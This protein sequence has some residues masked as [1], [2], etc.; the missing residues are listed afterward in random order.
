MW[1]SMLAALCASSAFAAM[2][3]ETSWMAPTELQEGANPVALEIVIHTPAGAGP[4]PVLLFN[5][6][7]TGR[8]DNP[9]LFAAT[10]VNADI[11]SY[12]SEKGWAVVFPQRRGRGKSGG[13]YDEGFEAD[14]SRY[15]CSPALAL[16][17][18]ERAVADLDAVM[19]A[20]ENRPELDLRRMLIGGQSRGGIL[21]VAYAGRRPERF[22]GVI[23][24]VGGW[25]SDR[26]PEAR[27][28]NYPPMTAG[29]ASRKPM[30]WLYG[31]NDPFYTIEHTRAGFEQFRAAGG[32]GSYHQFR[33]GLG[34]NGHALVSQP[35][36]WRS[37]MDAFMASAI[38]PR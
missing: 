21:A 1:K 36:L 27:A 5:H 4:F 22:L 30:L 34:S 26:C 32:E 12:F 38:P 35:R 15:S 18:L 31:E 9:A 3:A 10:Y 2:A 20:L 8:G 17:G 6:G 19:K 14:R 33:I 7:S 11:S 16:P 29:A 23:N 25:M 13:V 37:V 28:I 24:F